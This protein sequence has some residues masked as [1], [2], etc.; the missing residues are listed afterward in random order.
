[1]LYRCKEN[2]RAVL[3]SDAQSFKGASHTQQED[4]MTQSEGFTALS[5]G[6]NWANTHFDRSDNLSASQKLKKKKYLV[7][8]CIWAPHKPELSRGDLAYFL[9]RQ[10]TCSALPLGSQM[11]VP[12]KCDTIVKKEN[13]KLFNLMRFILLLRKFFR[14]N[15]I[16]SN[17]T[18]KKQLVVFFTVD[19]LQSLQRYLNLDAQTYETCNSLN[20]N[21]Q[22]LLFTL[23]PFF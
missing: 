13:Y 12:H 9:W 22:F 18:T 7:E 8:R 2:V 23:T 6:R 21:S 1:M 3:L 15:N 11:Y 17:V 14:L 10:P 16:R 19:D 5:S 20:S 4:V